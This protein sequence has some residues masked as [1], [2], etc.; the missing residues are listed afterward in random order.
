MSMCTQKDHDMGRKQPK[1]QVSHHGNDIIKKPSKI[2]K[3]CI[4]E[5]KQKILNERQET[6][7]TA[8]PQQPNLTHSLPWPAPC[9]QEHPPQDKFKKDTVPNKNNNI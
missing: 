5:S 8:V 7:R 1:A 6:K 3:P 9:T 2:N 4:Y